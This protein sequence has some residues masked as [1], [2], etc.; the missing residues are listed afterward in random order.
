MRYLSLK[1]YAVKNKISMFNVMKMVKSNQLKTITKDEKGKEVVYIVDEPKI[2]Y[3]KMEPKE[4]INS[5][6]QEELL[7]EI[8]TLKNEVAKLRA[9]L[10]RLKVTVFKMAKQDTK[11]LKI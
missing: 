5:T 6:K 2:S 10:N 9:E 3:Q 1:E 7:S 4:D 8:D 11:V